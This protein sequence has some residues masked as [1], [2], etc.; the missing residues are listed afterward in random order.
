MV[1]ERGAVDVR[2]RG[3]RGVG[4]GLLIACFALT[5]GPGPGAVQPVGGGARVE[6]REGDPPLVAL[7]FDDGPRSTTTGRL[8]EGLYLGTARGRELWLTAGIALCAAA[9]RYGCTV[10]AARMGYLSSR[11]VLGC[12]WVFHAV[13]FLFGVRTISSDTEG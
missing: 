9:V 1:L 2:G 11:A 13:Y 7:T 5:L 12:V 4:L 8:L 10:G 3:L 6:I